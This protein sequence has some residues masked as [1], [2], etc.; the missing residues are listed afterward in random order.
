MRTGC[1]CRKMFDSITR[2]RV[3]S[4]SGRSWRKTDFQTCVSVS[5]FQNSVALLSFGATL[6]PATGAAAPAGTAATAGCR[7]IER[8]ELTMPMT[9]MTTP[10]S[11]ASASGTVTASSKTRSVTVS[12]RL[13]FQKRFRVDPLPQLFLEVATLVD[14]NLAVIGQHDARAFE[15]A[16]R[17]AFEVDAAQVVAAAVARTLELVFRRQVVRRAPEM[18]ADRDE[19]IEA[20][21]MHDV[22]VGR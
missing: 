12:L 9:A 15:R 4:V 3:R 14:Q 22:V 10:T 7:L 19:R 13:C 5:Q 21:R 18:R 11:S 8:I 2:T 1:R 16:R 20:G 17:R 6:T